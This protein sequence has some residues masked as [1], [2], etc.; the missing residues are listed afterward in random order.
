MAQEELITKVTKIIPREDGSA[1]RIV[2]QAMFGAGLHRSIDVYVHRRE[3]PD[4]NWKL[5][6]D[7]PHPDWRTMS[8]EE[9]GKRGRS[10]KF[11]AV[12]HGEIFRVT[13]AIGKPMSYLQ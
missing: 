2:A 7:Q 10:E 11:Q 1:V 4:H 6:S 9:Y 5:C 12:S 13:N 8:V 3:S